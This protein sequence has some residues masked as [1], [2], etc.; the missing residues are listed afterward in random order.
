MRSGATRRTCRLGLIR[1]VM[2][3]RA[4]WL[5]RTELIPESESR[6]TLVTAGPCL[7]RQNPHRGSLEILPFPI[8]SPLIQRSYLDQ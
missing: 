5:D 1:R 6:G 3:R 2:P 4:R 7:E 8:R